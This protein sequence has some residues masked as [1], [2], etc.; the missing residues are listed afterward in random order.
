MIRAIAACLSLSAA[1]LA[2][3]AQAL[4]QAAMQAPTQAQERISQPVQDL[5][6]LA[7]PGQYGFGVDDARPGGV[8]S[9]SVGSRNLRTAAIELR[10]GLMGDTGLRAFV[11]LQAG[12]VPDLSCCGRAGGGGPGLVTQG[13][14]L[15]VEKRFVD[16]TTISLEGGWQHERWSPGQPGYAVPAGVP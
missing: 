12:H 14:V 15:G 8:A 10:S 1:A 13:A 11:A 7:E 5:G 2:G 9:L 3:P 16:G 4:A 6:P